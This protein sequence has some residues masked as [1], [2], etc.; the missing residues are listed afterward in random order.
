VDEHDW[1]P[2]VHGGRSSSRLHRICHQTIHATLSERELTLHFHTP[3]RLLEHP[4]IARF[5][6]WVR[7]RPPDFL[8]LSRR[9]R[10]RRRRRG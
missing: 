9:P 4:V 2:R 6:D 3:E 10:A 1:I 5:V 7:Q 8:D